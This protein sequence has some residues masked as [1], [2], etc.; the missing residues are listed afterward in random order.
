ML[1]FK[2]ILVL[3]IVIWFILHKIFPINKKYFLMIVNNY[4]KF[5]YE[6]D[7][8]LILNPIAINDLKIYVKHWLHISDRQ[9][10]KW[11]KEWI[12]KVKSGEPL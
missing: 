5:R 7:I 3:I 10:N 12:K 11:L 6:E 1:Y 8:K 2:I 4:Y 9:F